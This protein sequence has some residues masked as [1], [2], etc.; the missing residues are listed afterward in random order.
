MTNKIAILSI[1]FAVDV[2][3]RSYTA[4]AHW[5]GAEWTINLHYAETRGA[6]LPETIQKDISEAGNVLGSMLSVFDKP[7]KPQPKPVLLKGRSD[8]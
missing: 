8:G 2:G 3:D 7:A 5:T 4:T 1:T 6:G